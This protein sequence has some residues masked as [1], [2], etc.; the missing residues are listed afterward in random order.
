M[1]P[2][3]LRLGRRRAADRLSVGLQA[4]R[5][6]LAWQRTAL[7]V[8]GVSALLLHDVHRSPVLLVPV[9]GLGFA[10]AVLVVAEVRVDQVLTR[11]RAGGTPARPW[12]VRATALG[13]L[14][15]AIAVVVMVVVDPT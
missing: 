1:A 3:W 13:T 12:L 5:T 6:S 2:R 10:L 7:G 15:L 9:L 14:L 8:G 4:E 11:V